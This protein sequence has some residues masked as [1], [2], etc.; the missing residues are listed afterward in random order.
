MTF[1]LF[2]LVIQ[3]P[4]IM[5]LEKVIKLELNLLKGLLYKLK[6]E[7]N[8]KHLQLEKCLELLELRVAEHM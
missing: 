6:E 7:E 5:K 1:H 2:H 4:F 3:L 8:L